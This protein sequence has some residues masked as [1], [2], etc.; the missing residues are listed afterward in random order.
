LEIDPGHAEAKL[1]MDLMEKMDRPIGDSSKEESELRKMVRKDG[2]RIEMSKHF[3]LLH[4]TPEKAEKKEGS[5]RRKPRG[6]ERLELLE[7]VY[8]SFLL[9]FYSKGVELEIPTERLKVVL[10]NNANDFRHYATSLSPSLTSVDG[11]YDTRTNV[12]FFYDHGSNETFKSLKKLSQRFQD[13]K[14]KAIGLRASNAAGIVRMANTFELLVD[15]EQENADIIVVSH[16]ATHQMAG[17]TG[18]FPRHVQIPSWVHEGMATYFEAP[19]DA[20]WSGIGAVNE[21]RLDAYRESEKNRERSNIDFIAG[22]QLFRSTD[23]HSDVLHA[24]GQAWALTH[25][26]VEKHFDELMKYYDRLGEMPPH[27]FF[28]PELLN[29]LF[30]EVFTIDKKSLDFEWRAHVNSL[31]TDTDRILEESE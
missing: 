28:S 5:K 30:D 15:V 24:Y 3:I 22:D 19:R 4:D 9:A 21:E 29:K 20:T 17:N 2:M 25:F 27:V 6:E 14:K 13:L 8:E 23:S 31:K 10:F 11:F 18:L 1:M 26:L 7:K 12:S 16:E